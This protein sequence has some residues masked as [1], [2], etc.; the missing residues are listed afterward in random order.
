MGAGRNS[1]PGCGEVR[2]D[3]LLALLAC[4]PR[5]AAPVEPPAPPPPVDAAP[6]APPPAAPLPPAPELVRIDEAGLADLLQNDADTPLVINFW[7]TWCGPCVHELPVFA[8]VAATA[9]GVHFA[10]VS[11]DKRR[12]QDKV[13]P[14]LNRVGVTLPAFHL[15]VPDASASLGRVVPAWPDSIP[16]TLVLGPGGELRAGF[17]GVVDAHALRAALPP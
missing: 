5:H 4:A 2:A 3:V 13:L 7:A 12:D 1:P 8:E 16:V 15:D 6:P 10:L 11:V 17:R 14:Y 9:P